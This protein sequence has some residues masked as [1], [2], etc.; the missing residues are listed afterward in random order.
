MARERAGA[1]TVAVVAAL[2][3][4][5]AGVR[6]VGLD[7]ESLW[8]DEIESARLSDGDVAEV[9]HDSAASVHPPLYF[10]GLHLVRRAAGSSDAVLRLP[11]VAASVAGLL[12][13][14]LLATE[15]AGRP[16]ALLALALGAV[17]PLDVYYAQEARMY[18]QAAA[19]ATLAAW[20]LWR[21]LGPGGGAPDPGPAPGRRGLLLAYA[22]TAVAMLYTHYLTALLLLAQGTFALAVLLRR[23]RWREAGLYAATAAAVATS[24]LPW[25]VY[26][27]S[28]RTSFYADAQMDWMPRPGAGDALAFLGREPFWGLAGGSVW[29]GPAATGL[30]VVVALAALLLGVL[31]EGG[32]AKAGAGLAYASWLLVAPLGLAVAT[33]HL[34]RPVLLPERFALLVL[35]P[36]LVL[37][38]SGCV[39]VRSR[40]LGS[41]LALALLA[42]MATGAVV[43]AWT[44]LKTDWR[45]LAGEWPRDGEP[46]R[47]VCYPAFIASC[48]GHY[49]GRAPEV[50]AGTAVLTEAPHL[51][52][53]EV[54]VVAAADYPFEG[55]PTDAAAHRRLLAL[56]PVETSVLAGTWR[57]DRV[58]VQPVSVPDRVGGGS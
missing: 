8:F 12:L 28:L 54:W 18:A 40:V 45:G 57:L 32:P 44:P 43:Q 58:R 30:L 9:C 22:L 38:A 46:A 36:L 39:R 2:L 41:G 21:W 27:R 37:L 48:V 42:A 26:V 16:A 24:F 1:G 11:S 50:S 4:L 23:R 5:A 14:Y 19:L 31:R 52:G 47:L 56:G 25:I 7:R 34:Y 3:L 15:V 35:A 17:N 20:L 29:W 49:L 55:R 13:L 10:L 51:A 6:V 53:R 33:S